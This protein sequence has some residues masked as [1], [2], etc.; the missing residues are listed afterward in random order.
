MSAP[1]TRSLPDRL[2]APDRRLSAASSVGLALVLAVVGILIVPLVGRGQLDV[3]TSLLLYAAGASAWNLIGGFAGQFS[4]ANS[5]FVGAGAYVTVMVLR[6]SDWPFGLALL[7]A[8]AGGGVLALVAGFALFQL[9]DAL[10]VI[11]SMALALAALLWMSNWDF[12]SA[13][14]GISAPISSLPDRPT[15]YLLA[16]GV[17]LV[18][19]LVSVYVRHSMFGLRLMTVRDDE[20]VAAA[21]GLS[22]MRLKLAAFALS[23][24]VTGAMGGVLAL[25]QVTVEPVSVF[26][27]QWSMLFIVMAVVGGIGTVWGPLLG[28]VIVHLGLVVQLKAFPTL[29]L[30]IQGIVLVVLILLLPRGAL[31]ALDRVRARLVRA[32]SSRDERLADRGQTPLAKIGGDDRLG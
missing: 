8:A 12:T 9:R 30:L 20:G 23:G 19:I 28:A 25:Q 22:P 7:A 24:T 6:T 5:A 2:L 11:G 21:V 31:G 3:L 15:L 13:A 1:M 27:I 4:V 14:I 29:S 10:F 16:V 18:A 32:R 17:A 26:S